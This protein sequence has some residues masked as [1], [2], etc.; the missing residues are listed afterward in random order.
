MATIRKRG[1]RWQVQIRR[2]GF[3]PISRSFHRKCDADDWSRHMEALADRQGL[4]PNPKQIQGITV[5]DLIERYRDTVVVKKRGREVETF[6]LNALLRQPLASAYL[7]DV[8][9]ALF[10]SYRD[11]RLLKVRPVTVRRE[12]ALLQHIFDVARK[13][14]AV[15]LGDNPLTG[16]KKPKPDSPRDRRLEEG[17][18]DRLVQGCQKCRNRLIEPI[19][20]FAVETGMRR[21][22]ILNIRWADV[23]QGHFTLHIPQTK[24]GYPRTIPLSPEAIRI[25]ES[26][27]CGNERAVPTTANA[28]KLAWKRLTNRAG[29]DDLHFHDLR[30]EAIS[31]FFERGLTVPEVALISGHRDFRQLFRYTHLRAEDVAKK[32]S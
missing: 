7:A 32:L 11:K 19:I 4:P 16:I 29:V 23:D 14:W 28:L 25:L 1:N 5:K 3:A 18:L 9:P 30:H 13:E 15:P 6:I 20:Q 10:S 21:G 24:N 17:E 12:L 8:T 27:N 2:K 26:A 22:E 31:R